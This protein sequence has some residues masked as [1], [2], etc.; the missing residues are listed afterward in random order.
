[1]G[2][3]WLCFLLLIAAPGFAQ[4]KKIS[5]LP[6]GSPG[7]ATDAIPIARA[8]TNYR[9]PFSAFTSG[10]TGFYSTSLGIGNTSAAPYANLFGDVANTLTLRNGGTVGAPAGQS[11]I[12]NNFCDGAACVTGYDRAELGWSRTAN[13]FTIGTYAAGTGAY[14]ALRLISATGYVVL[15]SSGIINGTD[16]AYALGI[17]SLRW[18]GAYLTRWIQGSRSKT[19][20]DNT[21]TAFV[22]LSVADDDYE[23]CGVVYTA[24]AEDTATDARQTRTGR[25]YV[26]ILN[27]SGTETAVFSTG[28][29]AVAATAGTF[30]CTFDGNSGAADTIDL[31]ATCDTSLAA[32][33]TLTF[34]YRLDC[35]SVLTV[36][37]Q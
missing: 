17:S 19:L 14:R 29:S 7:Q 24:Y 20:T 21:A 18:T 15:D 9:L 13:A 8:G 33:T 2:R 1:M 30:T 28:D 3:L 32:T 35:P 25:V 37:P 12:I 11:F 23:G 22:R 5:A 34:E 6:D 26:A 27:N 10:A 4:D 16:D 36:T 31:R